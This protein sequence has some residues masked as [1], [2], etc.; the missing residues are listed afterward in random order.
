M[1]KFFMVALGGTA[2]ATIGGSYYLWHK[3]EGFKQRLVDWR[4][5][6]ILNAYYSTI[7]QKDIAWG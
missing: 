7:T 1:E 6:R 5:E 4:K 2:L 3:R